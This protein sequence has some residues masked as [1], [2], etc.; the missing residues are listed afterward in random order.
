[1]DIFHIKYKGKERN[2]IVEISVE[3][4]MRI[5]YY[6]KERHIT[7]ERLAEICSL[8]PT[9]IGQL[10]RGEKNATIE[11]IYRIAKGLDI[12]ISTLLENME[13]LEST[14]SNIP[15]DI[16]HQLLSL[17]YEQQKIMQEIIQNVISLL[18]IT[19]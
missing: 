19:K 2:N 13:Y 6:R 5:R 11:S 10:E 4:G 17:S 12:P 8:H 1:M 7:Q 18:Q 16:Y 14:S 3:L 9:Y 15:L